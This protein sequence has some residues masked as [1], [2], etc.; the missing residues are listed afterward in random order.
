[1]RR[2][3][4]LDRD[5]T[6]IEDTGYVHECDKVRL[7]PGVGEAIRRLNE[8][9]FRVIVISNQAGV[10][11]GFFTED[12]VR[13][14]NRLV[15][16]ELGKGGALID[17]IYYCPHH[18]DGVV[19]EYKRACD[20]RK[21]GTAMIEQAVDDF[22]IDLANSYFIGDRPSD[23]EAGR[24]AGCKTILLTGTN[25]TPVPTGPCSPDHECKDL[26]EAVGWVLGER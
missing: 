7:L 8:R 4:F 5:G 6:I 24:R 12:D 26:P 13:A 1:M 3:V 17:G 23:I 16:E 21:P 2:A 14:V 11:R 9:G 18:V 10:A 20:C 22:G 25:S 15:L 19:P